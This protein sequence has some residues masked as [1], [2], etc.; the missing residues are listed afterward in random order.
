MIIDPGTAKG[1]HALQR[2]AASYAGWLTTVTPEGQPQSMPVWFIWTGAEILIYGDRRA[3]RNR[4]LEANPKVSFHLPDE[5][6]GGDVVTF[7]GTARVDPGFPAA[8]DNPAY[9]AK[10]RTSIDTHLGGPAAFSGIYSMP[11][12]I[13]PTRLIVFEG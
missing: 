11:I 4:N 1:A 10:Y 6:R 7:E 9:L 2:L 13:E 5:G 8:G 12:L 3:R